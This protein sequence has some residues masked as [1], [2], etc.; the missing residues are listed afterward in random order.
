MK[1]QRTIVVSLMPVWALASHL[2]VLHQTFFVMGKALS[3]ELS[4]TGTCLVRK[5]ILFGV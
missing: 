5:M 3:G 2:T 4:C 1:V